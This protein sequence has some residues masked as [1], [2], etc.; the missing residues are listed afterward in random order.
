MKTTIFYRG[1][2]Q[3]VDYDIQVTAE[4][5]VNKVKRL[6]HA[7]YADGD[8]VLTEPTPMLFRDGVYKF[9]GADI[10]RT[11]QPTDPVYVKLKDTHS[12]IEALQQLELEIAELVSSAK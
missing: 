7:A 2:F 5:Y 9:L 3:E 1:A 11:I 4:Q 12:E 8:V 6:A 10:V